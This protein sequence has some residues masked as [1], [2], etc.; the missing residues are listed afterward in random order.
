MEL[1]NSKSW[2]DLDRSIEFNMETIFYDLVDSNS[3]YF[4]LDLTSRFTELIRYRK[5]FYYTK[6]ILIDS[7]DWLTILFLM[8]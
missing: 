8:S 1:I 4:D 7:S 5:N 2:F 3:R 6:I